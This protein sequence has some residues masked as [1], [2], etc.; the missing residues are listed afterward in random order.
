MARAASL[1]PV[2]LLLVI[3]AG[4]AYIGYQVCQLLKT[5]LLSSNRSN[6]RPFEPLYTYRCACGAAHNH[7]TSVFAFGLSAR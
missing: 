4:A 7:P 2:I 3:V 6:P 5:S 1:I